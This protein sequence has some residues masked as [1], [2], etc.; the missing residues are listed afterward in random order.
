MNI[1]TKA[2]KNHLESLKAFYYLLINQYKINGI[3]LHSGTQQYY[4]H[5]D[6]EVYFK[7]FPHFNHW[8]PYHKPDSFLLIE[9]NKKVRLFYKKFD[10]F[11][12]EPKESLQDFWIDHF[13]LIPY[14]NFDDLFKSDLIG[15][16]E[17]FVYL[18]S[19]IKLAEEKGFE[20]KYINPDNIINELNYYRRIKDE[21]ELLCTI[22]ATKIAING[23]KKAMESFYNGKD[24]FNINL[25]YLKATYQT[26]N[27][28]PYPNVIA[29]NNKSSILH[30]E[31]RR[32]NIP[33]KKYSFLIDAGASYLGYASDIT[34]TY[35]AKEFSNSLFFELIKKFDELQLKI[36]NNISIGKSFIKLHELTHRLVSEVLYEFNIIKLKADDIFDLNI[37]SIFFPHGL[38]HLLGL[39]VHDIGGHYKNKNGDLLKAPEKYPFLRLT[40]NIEEGHLFTI[41][42]GLYFIKSL[43]KKLKENHKISSS[44]NWKLIKELEPFGGIRIEDNIYV[45]KN[46]IYNLTRTYFKY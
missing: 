26:E 25:Q 13:E 16:Y 29:I 7:S 36:I 14:K 24:E 18:G 43:L 45:K 3:I 8:I 20:D 34:R 41:E 1:L 42:P 37:S 4:F 40:Q 22:E 46:S 9:P 10:D 12:Y 15:S 31:G 19:N 33:E 2:Y 30:Y 17:D 27:N 39:Q 32:I 11:W 35:L 23:H 44:V 5:D 21:Y 28:T 6:S 38:G